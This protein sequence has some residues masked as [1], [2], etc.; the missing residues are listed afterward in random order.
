MVMRQKLLQQIE[1]QRSWAINL[2]AQLTSMPA[3][4][5]DN[6]GRGEMDKA[7]FLSGVL[8]DLGLH[9]E[10]VDAP[11][12][13]ASQGVRPNILAWWPGQNPGCFV[14]SHMDVVPPGSR[15]LW[16]SDPWQLKIEG[17]KLYGRGVSDNH[18]GM[19]ASLLALKAMRHLGIKPAGRSGVALVS[20]EES[21]SVY[22]LE[23]L[24]NARPDFFQPDDLIIVPDVGNSEGTFIEVAEKSIFWLKVEVLGKQA[25]ASMPQLGCNALYAA[26]RMMSAVYTV[27]SHFPQSN[28]LFVPPVNTMEPT[29]KD[30]GV[31]NINTIPGRDVFYIDCRVLP[32]IDLDE[33]QEAFAR[34]F[35]R[36]A[37]ETGTTFSI[38]PVQKVSA[39]QG[40]APD[41]P[42]VQA[43]QAAIRQVRGKEAQVG[44]VGGNTVAAVFRQRGLP[45]ACWNTDPGTAHMPNE[46]VDVDDIIKDAQV[47][48]LL[49]SKL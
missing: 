39:P 24:L 27:R 2:M 29:R 19:L 25:H 33:V 31:E 36:I 15:E 18:S 3:L 41:A 37:S 22:G 17:N 14:L 44:G 43:L 6:N 26:A 16:H 20:D 23:Y 47:M 32:G 8:E 7:L 10:R 11:D 1:N 35:A 34:E 42:V 38:T 48:A 5:P 49:Y 30:A 21:G 9:I 13:R 12:A 40:T 28:A 46:W 4:G 45:V